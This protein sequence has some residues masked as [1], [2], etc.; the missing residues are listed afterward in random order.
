[1]LTLDSAPCFN[2][3]RWGKAHTLTGEATSAPHLGHLA[4][5]NPDY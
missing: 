4:N 2:D 3:F 1:M 5:F